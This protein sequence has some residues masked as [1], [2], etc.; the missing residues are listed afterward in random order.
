M[1]VILAIDV[2]LTAQVDLRKLVTAA[3]K[4]NLPG[5]IPYN[6]AGKIL[7]YGLKHIERNRPLVRTPS[8][9]PVREVLP[10]KTRGRPSLS[11]RES[12]APIAAAAEIPVERQIPTEML[13][14][15]PG[16]VVAHAVGW[17]L[18]GGRHVWSKRQIR[19]REKFT[20]KWRHHALDGTRD[21]SEFEDPDDW[22]AL[23]KSAQADAIS[24]K[25]D[26][27][28]MAYKPNWWEWTDWSAPSP[29]YAIPQ[30]ADLADD[31]RCETR[32]LGRRARGDRRLVKAVR[33][34]TR[35]NCCRAVR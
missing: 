30:T 23:A 14:Y 1:T 17:N 7:Q 4:F 32:L 26:W 34:E 12:T 19:G 31:E 6:S 21:L 33:A 15:P 11:A 2:V 13:A 35:A 28:A 29:L 16:S 22:L 27:Q 24:T 5:T 9:S 18:N 20:G 25:P 3:Q 10:P 8:P